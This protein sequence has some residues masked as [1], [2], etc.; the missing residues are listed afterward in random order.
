MTMNKNFR[1]CGF[2]ATVS[3]A[4]LG[5]NSDEIRQDSASVGQSATDTESQSASNTD[6]GLT[7]PTGSDS[8]S[9]SE[10]VSGSISDSATEGVSAA[11]TITNTNTNT[12]TET[13]SN[14]DSFPTESATN[15]AT[16]TDS[17]SASVSASDTDTDTDSASASDTDTASASASLTN[18]ITDTDPGTA[19]I[20]DTDPG[21]ISDTDTVGTAT[22]T[23]TNGTLT[24]TNGTMTNGTDTTDTNGEMCMAGPDAGACEKCAA[25]Q[26]E[27]GDFCECQ[28]DADCL[29]LLGCAGEA[30]SPLGLVTCAIGQCGVAGLNLANL[31]AS[32]NKIGNSVSALSSCNSILNDEQNG[33]GLVC[34]GFQ[35]L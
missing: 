8:Q 18:T 11:N 24:D 30:D 6:S 29:C 1:R 23:D 19:S 22:L 3:L 34:P 26:C 25:E 13:N 5:C 7:V 20:T 9:A 35:Y 21:T 32:L 31:P 16:D 12:N 27:G 28:M 15:S 4:L 10:T 14:S 33:C 17:A 2:L